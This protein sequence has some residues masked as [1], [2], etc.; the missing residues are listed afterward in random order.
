MKSPKKI[1]ISKYK[2]N[3][4]DHDTIKVLAIIFSKIFFHFCPRF[5]T[6]R[7]A[8]I[9]A[10]L[11]IAVPFDHKLNRNRYKFCLKGPGFYR[12]LITHVF[13]VFTEKIIHFAKKNKLQQYVLY[14][15]S[16]TRRFFCQPSWWYSIIF[17]RP[18]RYRWSFVHLGHLKVDPGWWKIGSRKGI[19]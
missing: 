6:L 18:F 7:L 4:G 15:L 3:G 19:P 17:F 13:R 2:S 16:K 12:L 9:S 8:W 1:R 14:V 10:K 5:H 11:E